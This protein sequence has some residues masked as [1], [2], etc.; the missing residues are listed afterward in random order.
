MGHFFQ[1]NSSAFKGGFVSSAVVLGGLLFSNVG[2]FISEFFLKLVITCVGGF[3]GGYCTAR[4]KKYF[5]DR[6]LKKENHGKES[7]KEES[8]Q[9][10]SSAA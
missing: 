8:S 3:L 4:G 6:K 7:S 2:N 10:K 1:E 5:E 9:K